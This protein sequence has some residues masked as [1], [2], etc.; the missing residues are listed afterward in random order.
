MSH[1]D[2]QHNQLLLEMASNVRKINREIINPYIPDLTLDGIEPTIRLVA[3]ARAS[4]LKEMFALASAVDD[5]M[6][7]LEQVQKLRNL[8]IVFEE[9]VSGAQAIETA[10]E[11]D[12]LDVE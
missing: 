4:Y 5:G 7:N 9:L 1:N 12:Y 6:P 10:I 2:M 8:R 3:L 11:R